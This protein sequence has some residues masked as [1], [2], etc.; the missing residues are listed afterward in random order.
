MPSQVTATTSTSKVANL[1]V[2]A[3]PP[4]P[5]ASKSAA[6]VWIAALAACLGGGAVAFYLFGRPP[7]TPTVIEGVSPGAPA[8][9]AARAPAAAPAAAPPGASAAPSPP[10]QAVDISELP[11]APPDDTAGPKR[12][13]K[14]AVGAKPAGGLC[15]PP[16]LVDAKGIKRLKPGCL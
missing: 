7:S 3:P 16:F 4:A 2:P 11:T 12:G 8:S 5:A 13:G 14:S 10:G 6:A 15:D 9:P 1:A